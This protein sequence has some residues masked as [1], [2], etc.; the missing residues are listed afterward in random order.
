MGPS[1][2]SALASAHEA[3]PSAA[4]LRLRQWQIDTD[5]AGIRDQEALAKLLN[6]EERKA[7]S[8]LWST[9][10]EVLKKCRENN[11]TRLPVRQQDEPGSPIMG[12]ISLRTFLYEPEWDPLRPAAS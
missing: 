4:V 9:V 11:L 5:L 10:A 12:V 2:L 3:Q 1:A 6:E 8:K 7:C